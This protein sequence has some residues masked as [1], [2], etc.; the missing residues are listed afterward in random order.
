MTENNQKTG[1]AKYHADFDTQPSQSK[2]IESVIELSALNLR[3]RRA[4]YRQS[5]IDQHIWPLSSE[6]DKNNK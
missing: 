2:A 4:Q 3:S 1:L 6:K 5:I